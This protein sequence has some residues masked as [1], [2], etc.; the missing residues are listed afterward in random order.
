MLV[1]L[2]GVVGAGALSLTACKQGRGQRC[3]V[4][5]DCDDGLVCSE[6]TQECSDST[7][8]GLDAAVPADAP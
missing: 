2:L 3:Q 1:V 5:S 4:Q 7:G 8:G 6:A